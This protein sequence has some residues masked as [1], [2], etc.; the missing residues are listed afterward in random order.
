MEGF[1]EEMSDHVED[2]MAGGGS[3][4]QPQVI[5]SR[6]LSDTLLVYLELL[7]FSAV[8]DCEMKIAGTDETHGVLGLNVI[9]AIQACFDGVEDKLR[10]PVFI[11]ERDGD[12]AAELPML[13]VL[14]RLDICV[15]REKYP[16][17]PWQLPARAAETVHNV[18]DSRILK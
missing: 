13:L 9:T 17:D 2:H 3:G 14:H 6:V 5:D 12:R 18:I 16:V 10:K 11:R 15:S 8:L 4:R 7:C 1:F